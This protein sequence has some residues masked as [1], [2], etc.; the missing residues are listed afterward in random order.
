MT[1]ATMKT[2]TEARE[3]ALQ[4]TA[5][6]WIYP[7][8]DGDD[9]KLNLLWW[10]RE[11]HDGAADRWMKAVAQNKPTVEKL[12]L[13]VRKGEVGGTDE[14]VLADYRK[15][16]ALLEPDLLRNEAYLAAGSAWCGLAGKELD[17]SIAALE[18]AQAVAEGRLADVEGVRQEA[19]SLAE[20]AGVDVEQ[21]KAV[22]EAIDAGLREKCAASRKQLDEPY[23]L[24]ERNKS[25][26]ARLDHELSQL[27]GRPAA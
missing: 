5:K 13:S 4:R 24:R 25:E 6:G 21:V 7:R 26:I 23:R 8:G 12:R 14:Y 9:P 27:T 20:T 22:F 10:Q 3:H 17:K 11:L 1:K 19:V 2:S 15:R 18:A 16:L